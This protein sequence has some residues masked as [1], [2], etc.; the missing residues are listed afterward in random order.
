MEQELKKEFQQLQV[1]YDTVINFFVN[2]SF[3]IIG[4][5]FIL[6]I[7]L[8][9]ARRVAKFVQRVCEAKGL[10]ITL[11]RFLA[12]IAK[13]VI[14]TMVAVIC[15]NKLGI[16]IT[17][18]IAAIGAISLGAGL[19]VQGL[20]SNYGAGLNIILTRYFVVGDTIKVQGVSGQVKDILLAYTLIVTEDDVEITIPNKHIVGEIIHNSHS[21]SLLELSVGVSYGSD[22]DQVTRLLETTIK[23]HQ[24]ASDAKEPQVGIAG[25]G[26]SSVDFE[27]RVWADSNKIN[28][29]RFAINKA[30]WDALKQNNIEIPFPQRE[31]KML[32]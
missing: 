14:V 26:D 8:F 5:L 21:V 20:L 22:L 7:G 28:A 3:Q 6:F 13:I 16:N 30:I 10:D 9:I 31:V 4:A 2:Y 29:A 12:N 32:S 1:V 11:S 24:D 25:F 27:V 15:L 23:N 19:A 18:L 17:P